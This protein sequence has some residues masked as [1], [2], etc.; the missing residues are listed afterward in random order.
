MPTFQDVPFLRGPMSP[1]LFQHRKAVTTRNELAKLLQDPALHEVLYQQRQ[2]R[3]KV[4]ESLRWTAMALAVLMSVALLSMGVSVSRAPHIADALGHW[5]PGSPSPTR[6]SAAFPFLHP[7]PSE[8]NGRGL[9]NGAPRSLA[10]ET[11]AHILRAA[12]RELHAREDRATAESKDHDTTRDAA[13][14]P[15]TFE[16]ASGLA[17]VHSAPSGVAESKRQDHEH[18]LHEIQEAA[19]V[20]PPLLQANATL[21]QHLA[22]TAVD[23]AE[24]RFSAARAAAVERELAAAA[25]RRIVDADRT[26][27]SLKSRF[28]DLVAAVEKMDGDL[29]ALT[30]HLRGAVS[31]A[32]R[33]SPYY[34][35]NIAAQWARAAPGRLYRGLRSWIDA[36]DVSVRGGLWAAGGVTSFLALSVYLFRWLREA[37]RGG[38]RLPDVPSDSEL[39]LVTA[40]AAPRGVGLTAAAG[41]MH[42]GLEKREVQRSD[43]QELADTCAPAGLEVEGEAA[44]RVSSESAKRKK[45]R[46]PKK[47]KRGVAARR[48]VG[49]TEGEG[50]E[51]PE[52]TSEVSSEGPSSGLSAPPASAAEM[53]AGAAGGELPATRLSGFESDV[54]GLELDLGAES[55]NSAFGSPLPLQQALE[56]LDLSGD[57]SGALG[58][59]LDSSGAA[60]DRWRDTVDNARASLSAMRRT[61]EDLREK[62]E[63]LASRNASLETALASLVAEAAA[64]SREAAHLREMLELEMESKLESLKALSSLTERETALL[65]VANAAIQLQL[66]RQR[67]GSPGS[68]GGSEGFFAI[69]GPESPSHVAPHMHDVSARACEISVDA[70]RHSLRETCDDLDAIM[71]RAAVDLSGGGSSR[72]GAYVSVSGGILSPGGGTNTTGGGLEDDSRGHELE[73]SSQFMDPDPESHDQP[74]HGRGAQEGPKVDVATHAADTVTSDVGLTRPRS[75]SGYQSGSEDVP[76]KSEL[77]HLHPRADLEP[78]AVSDSAVRR[79]AAAV[80]FAAVAEGSESLAPEAL[81]SELAKALGVDDPDPDLL[82]A[83]T[84]GIESDQLGE[85]A[86]GEDEDEVAGFEFTELLGEEP[87]LGSLR[88]SA[89]RGPTAASRAAIADGGGDGG[90]EGEEQLGARG[91]AA[92]AAGPE[93]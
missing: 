8:A 92:P 91:N 19:A 15:R 14:L 58:L 61:V 21:A 23:R 37:A 51:E 71:Q 76:D 17:H 66:Q 69:S 9:W 77:A 36:H 10:D 12:Q 55:G 90:G 18:E 53:A 57:S 24:A 43:E 60:L 32:S 52:P 49:P 48:G 30:R 67:S 64:K 22:A 86:A 27:A 34:T 16:A 3:R 89:R 45:A 78:A 26:Y 13:R 72:S 84:E 83:E 46:T 81:E 35:L 2:A 85:E 82:A 88:G 80:P 6:A 7:Q 93:M 40:S 70:L 44:P 47:K 20:V 50:A 31:R 75:R 39:Q 68:A 4:P 1:A 65:E 73:L 5:G 42:M 59:S 41:S 38:P 28:A 29:A 56:A 79:S 33:L 87:G 11:T 54:S 74:M 25:H 63:L 62:H